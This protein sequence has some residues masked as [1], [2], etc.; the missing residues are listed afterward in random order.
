MLEKQTTHAQN[1]LAQFIIKLP[2]T[3]GVRPV[4]ANYFLYEDF[5]MCKCELAN[6]FPCRPLPIWH[7]VFPFRAHIQSFHFAGPN[8]FGPDQTWHIVSR[9]PQRSMLGVFAPRPWRV[10]NKRK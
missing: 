3:D 6:C 9:T 8:Y 1:A 10:L 5:A 4:T 2:C 7:P